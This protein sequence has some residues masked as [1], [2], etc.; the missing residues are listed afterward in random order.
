MNTTKF[1]DQA[2]YEEYQ[3]LLA[4]SAAAILEMAGVWQK[5]ENAF[6]PVGDV[7]WDW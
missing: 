6:I 4:A 3:T 5:S 1:D 7:D 2:D